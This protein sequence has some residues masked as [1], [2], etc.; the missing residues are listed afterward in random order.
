[1]F[2]YLSQKILMCCNTRTGTDSPA[3]TIMKRL[4]LVSTQSGAMAD[5][6][7]RGPSQLL[8]HP[9]ADKTWVL[10][11]TKTHPL[12][13]PV[14]SNWVF[15]LFDS[16]VKWKPMWCT[17]VCAWGDLITRTQ[18]MRVIEYPRSVFAKSTKK[19]TT[20]H[21]I[22]YIISFPLHTTNTG[23]KSRARQVIGMR[24]GETDWWEKDRKKWKGEGT[25]WNA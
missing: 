12:P 9:I 1:M 25:T 5:I 4:K 7:R 2:N 19:S 24:D 23:R 3:S 17:M 13:L 15:S 22:H 11:Q 10:Q 20:I 6:Q 18:H 21:F 16:Q 8:Q 14:P